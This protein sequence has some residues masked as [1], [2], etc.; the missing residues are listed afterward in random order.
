MT[1]YGKKGSAFRIPTAI[2]DVQEFS[3]LATLA[4]GHVVAVWTD[5]S[6]GVGGAQGD[7]SNSA[8]KGQIL[9]A[10]GTKLGVEFLVNTATANAQLSP[11]V[12]ALANGGFFVSWTDLSAGVGGAGG[13]TSGSAVKGQIYD[14]NGAAVGSEFRINIRTVGDQFSPSVASLANGGY[15]VSWAD[16][17]GSTSG[18]GA[19]TSEYAVKAQIYAANGSK[20]GGEFLVNTQTIGGQLDT[21]VTGLANGSFVVTWTDYPELRTVEHPYPS[22]TTAD[23]SQS[24][25]KAQLY[26]ADGTPIGGEA[27][28]NTTTYYFQTEP[29]IT[30]LANGGYVVAW[31]GPGGAMDP[32]MRVQAQIFDAAGHKVGAELTVSTPANTD[33]RSPTLT[34][35]ANG[36][37]V[38]VWNVP[39]NNSILAQAYDAL[40]HTDGTVITVA[41]NNN[42]PQ[43]PVVT[44][45]ADGGF[46][47]S[48]TNFDP[49]GT[50]TGDKGY[51]VVGQVY[52]VIGHDPMITSN[53]ADATASVAAVENNAVVTT[54]TAT[55][56]DPGTTIRYALAGGADSA[57]FQINATTGVLSFKSSPDFENPVDADHNGI[58]EVTV[59]ARDGTYT[60]TQAISVKVT[61]VL[62]S[63]VHTPRAVLDRVNTTV[64]DSQYSPT[65]AATPNGMIS[66]WADD[67]TLSVR[68]QFLASDGSKIGGEITV[69]S[70]STTEFSPTPV[71]AHLAGGNNVVIWADR[72][73]TDV[74][75]QIIAADG[76]LKGGAFV[77][78]STTGNMQYAPGITALANGGFIVTWQDLSGTGGDT[79]GWAVRAQLYDAVGSKAGA[80]FLVNTTTTADQI[81]PSITAL[82]KGGFVVTWTD[83]SATLG[84][85]SG[86]A[87][88]GQV[89]SSNGAKLGGEFLVNT[90]TVGNQDHSAVVA[91][92]N[93]TFVVAWQDGTGSSGGADIKAQMFTATGAKM[94]GEVLVNSQTS[95]QQ[96]I[97]AV[98]ALA[99]GGYAIAWSDSSN[100]HVDAQLFYA[101]GARA[102][103]VYALASN[104]A[105]VLNNIA[106]A[107]LVDGSLG[108]VWDSQ[109][110]ALNDSD[111]SA[112]ALHIDTVQIPGGGVT[113]T[114]SA[115]PDVLNGTFYND[116]LMGGDG[117]DKLNGGLGTDTLI[118]GAGDDK[119]YGGDGSDV[120]SYA[121]AAGGV[122]VS[123][124]ITTAQDTIGAGIDTL[125]SI[126][127]L[128]G[129]SF[130]DHL[131]GGIGNNYLVGGNGNDVLDGGA[132]ND[133]LVGGA[134]ADTLTGGIGNDRFRFDVWETTANRDTITDFTAG[135]DSIEI[136]RSVFT[137]F[138]SHAPGPLG[139]GELAF[140]PVATT[141]D[142]HLIYNQSTGV[143]SYD[144]DGSG[145]GAAIE[146][147]V[148]NGHPTLAPGDIVLI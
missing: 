66:A 111:R 74:K 26:A 100:G 142:Q 86:T 7:T 31:V 135:Q 87:V 12:T 102:G 108:S 21:H 147:A 10:D 132:G 65:L 23:G 37:F 56:A 20:V 92:S 28:V 35:L 106:L 99:N 4:N 67:D 72:T 75:G 24:G 94:G 103:G 45:L 43:N 61:D 148:L 126:E 116:K 141:P 69:A 13:D 83:T 104:Y 105:A 17:A 78:N 58:Y 19:D 5:S 60:D 119:L 68:V 25:I 127:N 128:G 73:S 44:G 59:A 27:I 131:T 55:D 93:G 121:G 140:G 145:A 30:A 32:R 118:G 82:A 71:V 96:S 9:A 139:A 101:S 3:A 63:M 51:S 146:L 107:G 120:A 49:T 29:T 84:D 46:M 14:A 34:A 77:V 85:T 89:F 88:K 1:V 143:L 38:A 53:G 18:T 136:R 36:G 130:A 47:V 133:L 90:Q 114:G 57:L 80:E 129:S 6:K 81:D 137:A 115:A 52:Q 54:V 40:G 33:I 125:N 50:S 123:L 39:N 95:G 117:A 91:L 79:A 22:T 97:P 8:V 134:G 41:N 109:N 16:N 98:T 110:A 2:A 11:S 112:I 122:T 15:V 144:A 76:T 124:A 64:L 62:D 48:W 70:Y 42:Q 113:I 138:A